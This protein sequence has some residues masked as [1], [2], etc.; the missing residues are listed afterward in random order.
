M[1]SYYRAARLREFLHKS[2]RALGADPASP[3]VY[4]P[5]FLDEDWLRE[6]RL[7]EA[8]DSLVHPLRW[9]VV[10]LPADGARRTFY[11]RGTHASVTARA[12]QFFPSGTFAVEPAPV[13]HA[14]EAFDR[15]LCVTTT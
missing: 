2:G 5:P 3:P 9:C 14:P 7:R 6:Q 11:L 10:W 15:R 4:H 1:A 13:Q 12:R 8:I